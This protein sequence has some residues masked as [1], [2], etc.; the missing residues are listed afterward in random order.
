[1][2]NREPLPH[3]LHINLSQNS[4]SLSPCLSLFWSLHTGMPLSLTE[5]GLCFIWAGKYQIKRRV[6]KEALNCGNRAAVVVKQMNMPC[7]QREREGEV[8]EGD[9]LHVQEIRFFNHCTM[10][11][12]CGDNCIPGSEV[13]H[14]RKSTNREQEQ[15]ILR[16]MEWFNHSAL[17]QWKVWFIAPL[18]NVPQM[19][20]VFD[21]CDWVGKGLFGIDVVIMACM[22][23]EQRGIMWTKRER[24]GQKQ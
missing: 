16:L 2:P 14:K 7:D 3:L 5:S 9:R 23:I 12:G 22:C 20:F 24:T 15:I 21:V 10:T 1:M 17:G 8:E 4:I 18:W 13:S 11:A 19:F 6:L